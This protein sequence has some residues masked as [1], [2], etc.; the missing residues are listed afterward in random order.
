MFTKEGKN[1]ACLEERYA[2]DI[3]TWLGQKE[4]QGKGH[5]IF[6]RMGNA[7]ESQKC[8]HV[9]SRQINGTIKVRG[10]VE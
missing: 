8:V 10:E 6:N 3:Y 7:N 4:I 2:F 9:M 1:V 5:K